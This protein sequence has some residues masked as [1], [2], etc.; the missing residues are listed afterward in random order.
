MVWS[1]HSYGSTTINA[2]FHLAVY[3]V[4]AMKAPFNCE[5]YIDMPLLLE[6]ANDVFEFN[7]SPGIDYTSVSIRGTNVVG[8]GYVEVL[9]QCPDPR[10]IATIEETCPWAVEGAYDILAHRKVLMAQQTE[11]ALFPMGAQ[12]LNPAQHPRAQTPTG[13]SPIKLPNCGRMI[14]QW[15]KVQV[16]M[17]PMATFTIEK[18]IRKHPT[19]NALVLENRERFPGFH[20]AIWR[21]EMA[22][23]PRKGIGKKGNRRR[24][25]VVFCDNAL[26][27]NAFIT[28]GLYWKGELHFCCRQHEDGT[29]SKTLFTT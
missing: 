1:P 20:I 10:L 8:N 14:Q 3:R 4:Y 25:V 21:I 11:P 6:A 24:S 12:H 17:V 2:N 27:A 29:T 26:V 19:T 16:C 5:R 18:G 28:H 13:Q 22:K 23:K 9:L 7:K 15:Y